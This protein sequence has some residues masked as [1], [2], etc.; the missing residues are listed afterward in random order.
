MISTCFNANPGKQLFCMNSY[1]VNFYH[2]KNST[3]V[4]STTKANVYT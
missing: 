1:V 2:I 3:E 4:H